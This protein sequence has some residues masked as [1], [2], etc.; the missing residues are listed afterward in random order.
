LPAAA[1]LVT[2]AAVGKSNKTGSFSF[3]TMAGIKKE[4]YKPNF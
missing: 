1:F 2:L 4:R 3:R